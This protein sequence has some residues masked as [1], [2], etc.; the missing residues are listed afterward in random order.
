MAP[1]V[2]EHHSLLLQGQQVLLQ[3]DRQLFFGQRLAGELEQLA[4][5]VQ[6]PAFTETEDAQQFEVLVLHV[7]RFQLLANRQLQL[8]VGAAEEKTEPVLAVDGTLLA[9]RSG[10]E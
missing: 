7:H 6:G 4:Q 10:R 1:L 2:G 9:T 8:V 3:P 5:L